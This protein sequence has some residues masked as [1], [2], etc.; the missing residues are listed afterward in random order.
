MTEAGLIHQVEVPKYSHQWHLH[1]SEELYLNGLLGHTHEI[2]GPPL[3][4]DIV[5]WKFGRCYSHG[6]IVVEW[7]TI[8]LIAWRMG[9]H[10]APYD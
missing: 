9:A 6:A 3:P 10:R 1:R 2:E 4:G 7:P 8:I 5:L